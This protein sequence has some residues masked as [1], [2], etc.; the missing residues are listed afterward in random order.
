MKE[1]NYKIVEHIATLSKTESEKGTFTKEINLVSFGG[2]EP[3]YDIRSWQRKGDE[4][5][6]FKG[7]TLDKEEFEALKQAVLR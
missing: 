2:A 5:K 6:M 4:E 7:I 1:F 3:K